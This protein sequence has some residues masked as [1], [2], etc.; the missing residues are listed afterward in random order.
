MNGKEKI[1]NR[2]SF[3]PC[4]YAHFPIEKLSAEETDELLANGYFRNGLNVL[5]A[6]G[7]YISGEWK[8][9]VMLRIP[10]KNFQW[11]KRAR[12]LLRRNARHFEVR[13]A[14]LSPRS[15]IEELW[16]LFK[17]EIHQWT[18]VARITDYLLRGQPAENFNTFELGVYHGDRLVAFS[19]F[20]KGRKSIASL[21]AAYHPDFHKHSLGYY[22]MLLEL[23]YAIGEG[24]DWFYPGFFPKGLSM[25]EY[26]LRPGG[27]EFFR[28]RE[29]SWLP[30]DEFSERD[31]LAE[32]IEEKL[33]EVKKMLIHR[34]VPAELMRNFHSNIP[35]SVRK[36]GDHQCFLKVLRMGTG[37]NGAQL[38]VGFDAVNN[39]FEV[40]S[41]NMIQVTSAQNILLKNK[42]FVP[43]GPYQFLG[44]AKN[45]AEVLQHIFSEKTNQGKIV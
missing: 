13:I 22:T 23:E 29:T 34:R 28:L 12:K 2:L 36:A 7:R 18:N 37:R 33:L 9:N 17:T 32:E 43:S 26:K 8:P 44:K 6:Q 25:F 10:L 38:K 1:Q 39:C 11:K 14:P 20:D 42:R 4:Q 3:P 27:A 35:G 30:W 41:Q 15:E 45:P 21:E 5:S 40:F 24:L 31:W 19:L 16:Y